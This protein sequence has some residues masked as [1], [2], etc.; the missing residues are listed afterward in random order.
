MMHSVWRVT[1]EAQLPV[2]PRLLGDTEADIA[3]VGGGITGVTCAAILASAGRRVVLLE[4][5][6]L[7]LGSTGN[8]TGNL[9]EVLSDGLSPI[10]KKWGREV[11]AEVAA[12]RRQTVDWVE[13]MAARIGGDT[14]FRRCALYQYSHDD[15]LRIEAEY[16]ALRAA[17]VVARMDDAPLPGRP[18]QALIVDG[19]AQI[20]PLNY[21]QRLAAWASGLG[22]QIH[23]HSDA[24]DIDDERRV[25]STASG[26]VRAKEV[27]MATHT[28]KGIYG[29]HAQ[30]LTYR[31]Y[32]V[33]REA[34]DLPLPAGIF[35]QRGS[36]DRSFRNLEIAGRRYLIVVGA[37][38]KTGLHDPEKSL[39]DLDASLSELVPG[40]AVCTWSAQGY[41]SPDGLPYIGRSALG[42]AYIAT[43]FGT[44]GLTYGTLAAQIIAD[45]IIGKQNPW[46]HLY[47]AS[48]FTP[49]KS[50]AQIVE[51]Q[52]LALKGLIQDRV[53][54]PGYT[55]PAAMPPGTG[56]VMKMDGRDTALYRDEAG[57]LHA[58]SATCTHLGCI[59]HWNAA[60]KS[61]D[62]PCHGSRFDT[63][64]CVIEGPA[65][66][67]LT[68]VAP[69]SAAPD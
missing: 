66:S 14:R 28:P 38:G 26:A 12:S 32:G 53:R 1:A 48:R 58:L 27:V 34:P 7:G 19:Q 46:A 20:H 64:G 2:Y 21:V 6:T 8:S 59:V 43:G 69:D 41:R 39:A 33:A 30:M 68:P 44:D 11:A 57:G 61:W 50:A 25:V 54:V 56:T 16:A 52:T 67:P 62:C 65:L 31:E 17:N 51:E 9:Y 35:W 55:D 4:A 5:R 15:Q 22:V 3:V 10:E 23:E 40:D 37:G 24:T 29:V 63:S 49:I 47:R 60:E 42:N 18:S 45:D 13:Q 36:V